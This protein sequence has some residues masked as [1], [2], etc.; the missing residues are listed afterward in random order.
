MQASS[1]KEVKGQSSQCL[2]TRQSIF[3][4]NSYCFSFQKAT[5]WWN[6]LPVFV[7]YMCDWL[8]SIHHEWLQNV[9]CRAVME[10]HSNEE[11]SKRV[12]FSFLHTS[13]LEISSFGLRE[14]THWMHCVV[15]FWL[16]DSECLYLSHSYCVLDSR[17]Q[18]AAISLSLFTH[19]LEDC[20]FM[21]MSRVLISMALSTQTVACC[22]TFTAVSLNF[23]I[24]DVHS[25]QY[26]DK[27]KSHCNCDMLLLCLNSFLAKRCTVKLTD[28]TNLKPS[29]T[30][31]TPG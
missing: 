8:T 22:W 9:K 18:S 23:S 6:L 3:L 5:C 31:S 10:M 7:G 27:I 16:P 13:L 29:F 12:H 4:L 15:P 24:M 26:W 19:I 21:E 2:D 30:P 17:R 25:M 11:M 1:S 20:L 28:Y 14:Q